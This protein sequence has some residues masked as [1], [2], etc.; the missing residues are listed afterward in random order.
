TSWN[1]SFPGGTPAT[2]TD[3]IPVVVY[4]TPGVYAVTLT[5]ANGSGSNSM[6]RTSHVKVTSTT[7]QYNAWQYVEG[8]ENATTFANDWTIVNPQGNGWTR[9]TT[10]AATG[11]ACVKLANTTS[12]VGTVDEMVSPSI[13]MTAISGPVFTFKM[14]YRQRTSTDND[15]LRVYVSTNCGQTWSQR[16]TKAGATL[17]T[18]SPTTS[19]TYAPTASE[20]RTETVSVSNVLTSTNVRF[21]FTFESQGGNSIYIDDINITGTSGIDAPDAGIQHF[22]V[23]PNPVQDNT[24]VSFSLDQPQNVTLQL[25][26]MTGRVISEIYNGNLTAGEHQFPVQPADFL[27]NG[28]YFVRLTTAQGRTVTQKLIVE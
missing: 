6:T 26:D 14:A 25:F 7:A 19:S 23:F 22:D 2:S 28:L 4:N 5:V 16:Y 8:M 17:S 24:M 13:D 20:W 11:T 12:M 10:T 27:S 9:I 3:S 18:G 15:R 1:W 21:K